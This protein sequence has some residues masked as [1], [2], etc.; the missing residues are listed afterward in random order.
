MAE[1]SSWNFAV[2]QGVRVVGALLM[3]QIGQR[4]PKKYNITGEG[5]AT[6]TAH[7]DT[8]CSKRKSSLAVT[9]SSCFGSY[10]QCF[11]D[12]DQRSI[13]ARSGSGSELGLGPQGR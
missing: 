11:G 2:R 3:W 6:A 8:V 10:V 5:T 12:D 13:K 1:Q 4:M 7:T 9:V